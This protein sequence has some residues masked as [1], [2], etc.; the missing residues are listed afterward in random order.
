[1]DEAVE[2]AG[3]VDLD[4]GGGHPAGHV[5]HLLQ[6]LL[7]LVLLPLLVLSDH[8]NLLLHQISLDVL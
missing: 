8:P 1:M 5:A 3:E 2:D 7:D 4:D 6:V